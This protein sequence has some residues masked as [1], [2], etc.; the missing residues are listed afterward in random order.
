MS[1]TM[2]PSSAAAPTLP[3]HEGAL[4][5]DP[6]ADPRAEGQEHRVARAARR[7][8]APLGQHRGVA[9]VVDEHRQVEALGDEVADRDVLERQVVGGERDAA[10]AIDQARDAEADR[11]RVLAGREPDLGDD[12]AQVLDDLLGLLPAAEPVGPVADLEGLVDDARQQLRPAQVD[13]D[14]ATA[15]HVGHHT[16]RMPDTRDRPDPTAARAA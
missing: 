6:A 3:A 16:T 5:Q 15:G 7:A 1:M 11:R 13:A 14:H 4:G 10:L 2:W 12:L 8:P 9:V